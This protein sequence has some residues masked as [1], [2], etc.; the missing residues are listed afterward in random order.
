MLA[1]VK[2]AK[3]DFKALKSTKGP[4]CYG[5]VLRG[6]LEKN[7]DGVE[8]FSIKPV[9]AKVAGAE[10]VFA[11]KIAATFSAQGVPYTLAGLLLAARVGQT[12]L[13]VSPGRYNGGT[14]S[15]KQSQS[16]ATKLVKRA[17]AV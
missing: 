8:S 13:I 10:G 17:Q 7:T 2:L 11:Y 1:T 16:L 3:A 12:E 6:F 4:T 15:L 9:A 14:P 5:Q